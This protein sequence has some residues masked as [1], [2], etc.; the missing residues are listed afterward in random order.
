MTEWGTLGKIFLGIGSLIA[1]V[2]LLLLLAD[3]IPGAGNLLG[4]FGRLPGDI[5]VKRDNFSF[6]F[7]LG[8]SLLLSVIL[9][10]LFY[11]LSWIFRR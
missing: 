3:R 7:P 4:W 11:F 8:T 2:G 10:L 1:L 9:S 5:S 6:Y